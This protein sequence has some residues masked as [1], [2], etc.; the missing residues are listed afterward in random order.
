VARLPGRL[1]LVG[2]LAYPHGAQRDYEHCFDPTWG[3]FRPRWHAVPGNHDYLTPN[4]AGYFNYF[5]DAAGADRSGYYSLTLGNWQV[6][7]LDS[8]IP[9]QRG[10]AQWEFVRRELDLQPARCTLALW[11]HPLFSSGVNGP[12]PFMRDMYG[13]LEAGGVEIVVNGHDHVYERFAKQTADGRPSDRG[14]RQFIV[15]T[16]GAELYRFATAAP[17]SEARAVQYGVLHLSLQ[18]SAYRW[19]FV[20]TAGGLADSGMDACH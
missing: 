19:Q 17:N 8:N 4:A 5:G 3:A 2:D 18:P 9:A 20:L 14:P 7:M 16:G 6:L 10:S 1:L 15:G 11:H 12:H 13:L